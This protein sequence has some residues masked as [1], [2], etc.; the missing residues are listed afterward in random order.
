MT[1]STASRRS[2]SRCAPGTAN[3]MPAALILALA[4][5][6]RGFMVSSDTRN[7]RAISAV[8]QTAEGA[9][10]ER[11][12][13]VQRQRR[14]AAGEDRLEP[15][16]LD[17]GVNELVHGVHDGLRCPCTAGPGPRRRAGA[18]GGDQLAGQPGAIGGENRPWYGS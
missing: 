18:C 8:W 10:R 6:S 7:A 15:L 3:G 12:L 14:V 1:A 11:H 17:H 2:G 4:R 9:Q 16:V 13:P 5:D